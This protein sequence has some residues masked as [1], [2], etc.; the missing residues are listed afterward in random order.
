MS[1]LG[2]L[3][4]RLSFGSPRDVAA[5]IEVVAKEPDAEPAISKD[6]ID[7]EFSLGGVATMLPAD[8]LFAPAP[9]CCRGGKAERDRWDTALVAEIPPPSTSERV[10]AV[11]QAATEVALDPYLFSPKASTCSSRW[12]ELLRLRKVQMSGTS[13]STSL[14][15]A[16]KAPL[17]AGPEPPVDLLRA[18]AIETLILGSGLD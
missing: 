3:G 1:S 11:H 9:G 14:N 13:S 16:P 15:P 10:R 12:W 5:V 2:W 17:P 8:E 18:Q 7:F 6:F 4:P